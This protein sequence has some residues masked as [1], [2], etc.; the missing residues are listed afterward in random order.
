[1]SLRDSLEFDKE[2]HSLYETKIPVSASKIS[3]LTKL[4]VKHAKLYK[5]VVFSIEKFVQKCPPE[6]KLAG[7]YVIDSIARAIAKHPEEGESYIARFEEKLDSIIPHL[8]QAPA[9]DKD[10]IKRTVGLWKKSSLFNVAVIQEVERKYFSDGAETTGTPPAVG[11]VSDPRLGT[12]TTPAD[13]RLAGAAAA[14]PSNTSAPLLGLNTSSALSGLDPSIL[15]ALGMNPQLPVQGLDI[16]ALL[17]L[18]Q[19]QQAQQQVISDLLKITGAGGGSNNTSNTTS[20]PSSASLLGQ[21]SGGSAGVSST[22]QP[23]LSNLGALL[24]SMGNAPF[25]PAV[26]S[27]PGNMPEVSAIG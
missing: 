12:P 19:A 9:K 11:I 7:L 4:A 14:L 1:M 25:S 16:N 27:E 8:L 3:A 10:R 6:L 22:Q 2:L 24:Q 13:P 23:D 21:L 18:L 5:N 15:Q 17:P 20:A 26:T